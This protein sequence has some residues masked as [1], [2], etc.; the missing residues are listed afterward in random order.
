[1]GL[2][3]VLLIGLPGSGKT[4]LAQHEYAPKGYL[5]VDDPKTIE[6]IQTVLDLAYT[7]KAPGVVLCDP[8]LVMAGHREKAFEYLKLCDV[9]CVYFENDPVKAQMN[10]TNRQDGRVINLRFFSSFYDIPDGV[11]CR[12]IWTPES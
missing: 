10:C 12:P 3:V 4:Y 5:V 9:E 11:T 2:K 8:T 1:M 6:E 7:S